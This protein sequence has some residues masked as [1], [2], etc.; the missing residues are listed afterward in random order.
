MSIPSSTLSQ[1]PPT[2]HPILKRPKTT[3]TSA[4]RL[5]SAVSFASTTLNNIDS[6]TEQGLTSK[7]QPKYRDFIRELPIYLAKTI[8][9][10]LNSKSLNQCKH[11]STYWK[12][13]ALEVEDEETMTRMLYDDMM[14]LQVKL[15]FVLSFSFEYST[16]DKDRRKQSI[17]LPIV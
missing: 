2:H 8:L 16:L 15:F 5:K 6:D 1:H 12:K 17:L 9:C 13:L 10:M 7:R 4:S 3:S 14:L 11:V